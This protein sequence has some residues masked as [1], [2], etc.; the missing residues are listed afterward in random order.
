MQVEALPQHRWLHKLV[1]EW[2]YEHEASMEPGQEPL[3]VR[4]V[5]TVRTLGDA[6]VMCYGEGE[7]PDGGVGKT[8]MTLGYD[9][10]KQRFVGSFIGSMMAN[11]WIYDGQLDAA[12][13]VLLLD[14][15]GPSFTGQGMAKY[16]D[17]IE[18]LSD[19]HRTLTAVTAGPDGSW[20]PPFMTAHYRRK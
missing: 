2:T 18:F 10:A 5:E 1:G 11:L 8:V 13:N 6:W 14:S 4:G 3:K 7:W 16:Q 9:P 20:Q 17:R 12:G 15:E 19:D